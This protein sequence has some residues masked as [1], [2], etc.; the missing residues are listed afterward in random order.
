MLKKLLFV[1]LALTMSMLVPPTDVSAH[2]T[3]AAW[4]HPSSFVNAYVLVGIEGAPVGEEAGGQYPTQLNI[5][6]VV[7]CNFELDGTMR[8]HLPSPEGASELNYVG[9]LVPEGPTGWRVTMTSNPDSRKRQG[10]FP[11]VELTF[12]TEDFLRFSATVTVDGET[13][14]RTFTFV[15]STQQH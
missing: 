1:V 7:G 15:H 12:T 3:D 4:Y 2:P 11:S 9:Q 14:P 10:G 13:D 6:R 5:G 8:M